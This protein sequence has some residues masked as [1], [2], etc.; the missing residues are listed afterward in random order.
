MKV[1]IEN[2]GSLTIKE[3][4][5]METELILD[6]LIRFANITLKEKA[7]DAA[8]TTQEKIKLKEDRKAVHTMYKAIE[9]EHSKIPQI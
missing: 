2:D 6:S 3:L 9:I 4:N 1:N 8:T 7:G 5:P